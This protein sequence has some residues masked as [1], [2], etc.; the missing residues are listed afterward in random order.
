MRRIALILGVFATLAVSALALA[1][2]SSRQ[3]SVRARTASVEAGQTARYAV[4]LAAPAR[5]RVTGL[6]RGARAVVQG[7]GRSLQLLVRTR[8]SLRPGAYR[9]S[10]T[11]LGATATAPLRVRPA[12]A[13]SAATAPVGA[14]LASPLTGLAPGVKLPVDVAVTNPQTFSVR[15][16]ALTVTATGVTGPAITAG[17]PC[18]T[19]DFAVTQMATMPSTAIPA[20]ATR[21]LSQLGVAS[22][23]RPQL[24]MLNRSV[25]QDG[26]KGATVALQFTATVRQ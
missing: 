13:A 20:G 24:T 14:R 17:T 15:L 9:L 4:S 21:S 23:Q 19:S 6:P 25:A 18:T 8:P 3:L 22:A 5:V 7:R 1:A 12:A 10:L 11:A 26:C 2:V 16:N